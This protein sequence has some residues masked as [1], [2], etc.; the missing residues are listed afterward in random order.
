HADAKPQVTA[1]QRHYFRRSEPRPDDVGYIRAG[2]E[3]MGRP[4]DFAG[5]HSAVTAVLTRMLA[6]KL[7][8]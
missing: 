7:H 3:S 8:P 4:P 6:L 1:L 2:R 5:D